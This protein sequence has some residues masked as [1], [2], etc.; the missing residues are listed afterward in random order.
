[1][2]KTKTITKKTTTTKEI[3][4]ELTT[5]IVGKL[6]GFEDLYDHNTQQFLSEPE[7]KAK[8]A[9]FVTV[10]MDKVLGDSDTVKK[11]R[12]TKNPTPFIRKVG[13]YQVIANIDWQSYVNR[14]SSH[15][16]FEQATNRANGVE[17]YAECRAI[18]VTR[19]GNFTINGVAF[20][21]I[22]KVQYLDENGQEYSDVEFLKSEYLKTPS[23]ASLQKEAD[24]HGI[25]VKFDPKYRTTR[26]DSCE[27][28]RGFG[29]EYHPI[30][31]HQNIVRRVI[32][33][34]NI[35]NISSANF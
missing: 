10:K 12:T 7:L 19:A 28:I 20:K 1:M 5:R 13:A 18:G 21:T 23:K 11:G 26:I 6:I 30:E 3:A 9:I 2:E 31:N 29:Y 16:Q 32:P 14:R 33:V 17:N 35:V 8:G 4:N 25:E 34:G 27:Y 24:K 22:E 15:G